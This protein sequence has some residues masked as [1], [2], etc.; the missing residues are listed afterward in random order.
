MRPHPSATQSLQ[1]EAFSGEDRGAGHLLWEKQVGWVD[2]VGN[3]PDAG[4]ASEDRAIRYKP[5]ADQSREMRVVS[6]GGV[7]TE[8][9][10]GPGLGL[11]RPLSLSVR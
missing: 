11:Q 6:P 10:L 4:I 7:S 1:P 9:T 5:C 8:A 2:V 3:H